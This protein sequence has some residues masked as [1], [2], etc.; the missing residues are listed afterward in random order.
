[1][2]SSQEELDALELLR[3]Q[4]E[5]TKLEKRLGDIN[6]QIRA[7][8]ERNEAYYGLVHKAEAI[9]RHITNLCARNNELIGWEEVR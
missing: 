8:T 4:E 3:N 9:N 6:N 5:I 1:M 2:M 7:F